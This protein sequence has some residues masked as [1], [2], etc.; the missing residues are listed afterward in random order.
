MRAFAL[1]VVLVSACGAVAAA[2]RESTT[3]PAWVTAGRV[4]EGRS[5]V[6][7][8]NASGR[9]LIGGSYTV[10]IDGRKVAKLARGR[11]SAVVLE[12]GLHDAQVSGFR[13]VPFTTAPGRVT[14]WVV[15]YSP[16]KSWAAPLGGKGF[17]YGVVPDSLGP[18]LLAEHRWVEPFVP[19]PPSDT[20]AAQ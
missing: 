12:P 6:L 14:H 19:L 10:Q 3:A 1:L 8:Y 11:Y 20:T 5:L 16:A 4:P 9:T 15:A 2:D 17:G 13:K 7:V 18:A